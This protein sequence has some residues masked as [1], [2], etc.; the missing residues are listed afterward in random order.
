[1]ALKVEPA[2]DTFARWR[3]EASPGFRFALKFSRTSTHFEHLKDPEGPLGRFLERAELL[4]S[5]LGPILVQLP[6]RWKP[7]PARLARFLRAAPRRQRIA[8]ELRDRRW[9]C[10]E[11]YAVLR[12]HRAALVI[13]DLLEDHPEVLTCG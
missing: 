13:H 10:E 2:P 12:E 8:V 9:L 7:D 4:K 11:V 6:P 5:R 1:M 3:D